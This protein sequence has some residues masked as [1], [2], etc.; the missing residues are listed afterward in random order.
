M[1]RVCKKPLFCVGFSGLLSVI[2]A[3]C[4]Q[5]FVISC[6]SLSA[7]QR[8]LVCYLV[9]FSFAIVGFV[10]STIDDAEPTIGIRFRQGCRQGN[11]QIDKEPANCRQVAFRTDKLACKSIQ[12]TDKKLGNL[13]A[14]AVVIGQALLA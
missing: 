12:K 2:L 8:N 13:K 3:A 11:R 1:A 9:G 6:R 14:P 10:G 4:L 7:F 5:V